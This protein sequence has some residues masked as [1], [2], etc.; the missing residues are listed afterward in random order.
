MHTFQL[1]FRATLEQLGSDFQGQLTMRVKSAEMGAKYISSLPGAGGGLGVHIS[2]F[3]AFGEDLLNVS[4]AQ[5]ATWLQL[6]TD[7]QRPEFE[8]AAVVA[9]QLVDP[10]GALAAQVR[11]EGIRV[12]N[13]SAMGPVAR[14][15]R[16]PPSPFYVAAWANAPRG[17]PR[18]QDYA[19]FDVHSNPLRRVVLDT[20]LATGA[21]AISE[22]SGFTFVDPPDSMNPSSVVIAPA[23][24]D[25]SSGNTYGVLPAPGGSL[26]NA[27]GQSF[28]AIAFHWATVVQRALPRFSDG[29]VAVLRS[30]GATA[31]TF[32]VSGREVRNVGLGDRHA[33]LVRDLEAEGRSVNITV[34]GSAWSLQVYP[35]PEVC[36]CSFMGCVSRSC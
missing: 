33:P 22:I 35:T 16:A 32:A 24:P 5:V 23:W 1:Q 17:V 26:S 2:G 10:S 36:V 13:G 30:P 21:P 34:A 6:V 3:Q 25:N 9:A 11:A 31:F 12:S 8:A 15:E 27:T 14:F 7:A 28:C 20:V 29:I 4:G 19:L 18:L